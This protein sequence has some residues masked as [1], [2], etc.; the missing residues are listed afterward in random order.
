MRT[1]KRRSTR[2]QPALTETDRLPPILK[3]ASAITRASGTGV[4]G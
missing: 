4:L 2:G 1:H 3:R